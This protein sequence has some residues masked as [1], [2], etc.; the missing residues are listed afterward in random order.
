MK[1]Q[2]IKAIYL[3]SAGRLGRVAYVVYGL[4]IGLLYALIATILEK[5]LGSIG[6]MI[7]LL[8]YILLLYLHYNLMAKR[9]HD[10]DQPSQNA[11]YVLVLAVATSIVTQ[12]SSLHLLSMLLS[13]ILV[14]IGLYLV[15]MPGTAG[16]NSHGAT[17]ETL[18]GL[19]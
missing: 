18:P 8:F 15:L 1:S 10:L 13:L 9:F 7:S 19:Q 17:P 12:I 3:D 2:I 6:A 11:F 4:A 5:L 14:A 16:A